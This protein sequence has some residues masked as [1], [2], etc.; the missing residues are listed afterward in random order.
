MAHFIPSAGVRPKG[1]Y[2]STKGAPVGHGPDR[3]RVKAGQRE[4]RFEL[5]TSTSE[6]QQQIVQT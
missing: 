6:E 4:R 1:S 2:N 5:V 3:D